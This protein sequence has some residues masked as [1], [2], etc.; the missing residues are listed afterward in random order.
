MKNDRRAG[1]VFFERKSALQGNQ[2]NFTES[3]EGFP[4]SLTDFNDQ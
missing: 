2:D 1:G 4:A 3:F